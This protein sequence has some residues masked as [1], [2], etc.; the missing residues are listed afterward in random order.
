M[1]SKVFGQNLG[2]GHQDLKGPLVGI[3]KL[4]D[5]VN[6]ILTFIFPFGAIILFFVLVWGGY[7]FLISRGNPEKV[8]EAQA[9]IT[10]GI[11]GFVL[12]VTSYIIVKL[13]GVIF[14]L[15]DGIL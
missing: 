15:G 4:S 9:K 6:V 11:I 3:D 2:I 12:L 14:G 13:I 7:D 5:V 1:I 8:K 10:T